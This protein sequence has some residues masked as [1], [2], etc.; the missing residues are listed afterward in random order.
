VIIDAHVHI[1]KASYLGLHAT[2][3][4]LLKLAD[5]AGVDRMFCTHLM[6]LFYDMKEGN[7][8]LHRI[9]RQ[10][11]DRLIGYI[12]IPSGRHGQDAFDEIERGVSDYGM[13]GLKIYSTAELE[14]SEPCMVETI[15]RA[16]EYG[17]PIL[18][19]STPWAC[20]AVAAQVP[21][22]RLIM[23]HMG[24]TAIAR[25]DWNWAIA[26]AR[27]Y[28]NIYLDVASST[29]DLGYVEA[30]VEAVGPERVIF[31][32][33]LPIFDPY[34]Q[35]LKVTD[36]DIDDEAKRLILGGNIARLANLD[37]AGR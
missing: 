15:A 3:D 36:A 20:E 18:A 26:A 4:Q 16:A 13:K 12:S 35:M 31:G 22:A 17:L 32:S 8:A 33:D 28:P 14:I 2:A 7:R 10:H 5:E 25:G 19:H 29:A 23:A 21:N 1:G 27:R 30:A 34:L 9:L 24:N 11:P 6:A 37:V